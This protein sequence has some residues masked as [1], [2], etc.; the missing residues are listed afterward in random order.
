[1][2]W[3]W[4]L[5]NE[6]IADGGDP[7]DAATLRRRSPASAATTSSGRPADRLRR[8]TEEYQSICKRT[9]TYLAWD[10]RDV[11]RRPRRSGREYIDVTDLMNKVAEANPRQAS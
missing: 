7:F 2:I 9:E 3:M 5:A 11:H 4:Q 6:V 1:M 8:R 10:G